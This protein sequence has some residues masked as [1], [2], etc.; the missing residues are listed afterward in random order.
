[1]RLTRFGWLAVVASLFL[2]R[3][4][5]AQEGAKPGP[6]HEQLKKLEGTWDTVMKFGPM[7]S[8]GTCV[9]KMELGGLWLSATFEGNIGGEKFTGKG[10][11]TYDAAKKKYVG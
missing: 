8:K 7:E 5:L 10:Y 6:E 11:D 1:M 2:A 3:P 9:Y 4:T